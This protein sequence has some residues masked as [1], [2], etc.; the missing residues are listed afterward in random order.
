MSEKVE[1]VRLVDKD[2][3]R[4]ADIC[5]QLS[6]AMLVEP[7]E[8]VEELANFWPG[9]GTFLVHESVLQFVLRAMENAGKWYPIIA[10]SE[11]PSV[12]GAVRALNLGAMNFT[13]WP[14]DPELMAQQVADTAQR[15]SVVATRRIQRAAAKI[16]VRQLSRR[17]VQ[18]LQSIT[19]GFSNKEIAQQLGISHRTVEIHRGNLVRR[20]G[21][22]NT[23]DV[24]RIALQAGL[25][26]T[27]DQTRVA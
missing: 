22:K 12:Q 23:A 7:Y 13:V 2:T 10:F 9:S 11:S 5:S 6:R 15:G 17:E 25:E 20:L 16:Q 1:Y 21:A 14:L 27:A 3:R 24:I 18:V 26:D 19:A 4:R 8:S